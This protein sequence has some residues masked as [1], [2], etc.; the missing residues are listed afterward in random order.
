MGYFPAEEP[1]Y[2]CVVIINKPH[3]AKGY[4]GADVSGPVFRRIAQKIFTDVPSTN[5]IRE[6]GKKIKGQDKLFAAYDAKQ[7]KIKKNVVPNILGMSGMDAVALLGNMGLKVQVL[8]MGKVKRQSIQP[9]QSF[10]KN[11]TI[12]LELS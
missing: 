7:N 11:Q 4:Y 1:Q 10:N 3:V 8:G 6:P 9:G 12:T 5:S 2:S